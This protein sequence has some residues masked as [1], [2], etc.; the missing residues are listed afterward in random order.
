MGINFT[1]ELNK[2]QV[3]AVK[4]IDGPTLVLAGAGSGK[5]RV[6]TYRIAHLL[7]RGVSPVNILALTF[8]NKA[9]AEMKQ[10]VVSLTNSQDTRY[11]WMGTFHS[12]FARIL[13]SEAELLGY[14]RDFTIYDD[15]DSKN[16][17][18]N[19]IKE[20]QLDD[21]VYR[22]NAV[23]SR[24]SL[25]KN[26]LI[27]YQLYSSNDRYAQQDAI[28]KTPMF[29]DIYRIYCERCRSANAM[30]FDDL[31]VNTACLFDNFSDSLER[32]QNRFQYIL[33]DEFQDTN[34]VQ[35][36]IVNCL[37]AIHHNI[38][39]VGDDAQSIYSFRG[40]QIENILS[41]Q[42]VFPECKLIKL[43]QNY[44]STKTIV[45][46][47]NS[48][49]KN[50]DHQLHKT[51]YSQKEQGE[52]INIFQ[53]TI[54][55]EEGQIVASNIF[56]KHFSLQRQWYDFAILYRTNGQSRIIEES[57]RKKN[58]PYKIYGGQS[59]YERKEIKDMLAYLRI[60]VNHSDEEALKRIINVPK[61]AI[62]ETTIYKVL[63]LAHRSSNMSPF[64]VISKA[65]NFPNIFNRGT[66]AKLNAFCA[67]INSLSSN[68]TSTNAYDKAIEVIN[69]TGIKREYENSRMAEDISRI[70][71]IN[72][73]LN[74]IKIFVEEAVTNGE[75]CD[76]SR[77]LT[78]VALLT[79]QDNEKAEDHN[80]VTL[81]TIHAS[82]GLEFEYVYIVGM[83][84]TLFP[85]PMSTGPRDLEEERRL[86]YVALTRAAKEVTL[87]YALNRYKWGNL[88]ISNPSRFL[89]E[90]D[91]KYLQYPQL[92]EI[93]LRK[94]ST[95][96][97]RENSFSNTQ[98]KQTQEY[99][100]ISYNKKPTLKRI[101][102]Q[103]ATDSASTSLN[104]N[105][106]STFVVGD[107]VY[108]KNFGKGIVM[109]VEGVP[110]NDTVTVDFEGIGRKKL[111]LRF[112]RLE[113]QVAEI[114]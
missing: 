27:T 112:A 103:P 49:I 94:K 74:G 107:K 16:L 54:D 109:L 70:E 38:C 53:A 28:V 36:K 62:G 99:K 8:T 75:P 5:T 40:A 7:E 91:P 34:Y 55:L 11:L 31:L 37:A 43:E 88:E 86:F 73:L 113:K 23:S 63:E 21:K 19:I 6:L 108:H 24:I 84:D 95:S 80:K 110:P 22:Y 61:R 15:V 93:N 60:I 65:E 96:F 67:M 56:D 47:A 29:G 90:I 57:L 68:I 26:N 92:T 30:D 14:T 104:I 41:F 12:I 76:L 59:F 87:S 17:V 111:L 105:T 4:N 58:I 1:K 25:A 13:R 48:I 79:D 82:K 9:A 51:V 18:R 85:S 64:E 98:P 39:V 71:N 2:A 3:E 46:V 32:F 33:V 20:L 10:R 77:Y 44:R 52:K 101:T 102:A 97:G 106:T 114:G 78:Q 72:E 35:N 100:P 69:A 66:A 89:K 83:E 81:M 50:N 45:E 42:K